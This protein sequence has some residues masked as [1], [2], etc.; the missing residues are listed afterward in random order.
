MRLA[1]LDTLAVVGLE[2]TADEQEGP[3]PTSS[4]LFTGGKVS[5]QGPAS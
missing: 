4:R 5:D 3:F 1:F 2:P